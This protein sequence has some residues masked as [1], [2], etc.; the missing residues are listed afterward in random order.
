MVG[1]KTVFEDN[2]VIKAALKI[3]RDFINTVPC[4]YFSQVHKVCAFKIIKVL[5]ECKGQNWFTIFKK[6]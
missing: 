2:R 1:F 5:P 4:F 6:Y 3:F